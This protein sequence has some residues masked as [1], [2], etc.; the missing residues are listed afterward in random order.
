MPKPINFRFHSILLL[1]ALF[2]VGGCST[3]HETMRGSVLMKLANEAH[4]CI[5][6]EDGMQVGDILIV[7]R[8]KL[9]GEVWLSDYEQR[10][11]TAIPKW[12]NYQKVKVG[13]IE[14]TEIFNQHFAAVKLISG[15]LQ[16]S[17]IVEKGWL[18]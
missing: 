11:P 6:S 9:D 5:G 2:G 7:Y 15:E 13:E 10:Y 1:S 18:R 16:G 4:I 14:V 17:D 3:S 8:V 12:V